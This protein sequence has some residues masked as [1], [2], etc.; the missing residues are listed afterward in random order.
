MTVYL[1]ELLP[2]PV[3]GF[4]SGGG[5]LRITQG[6]GVLDLSGMDWTPRASWFQDEIEWQLDP[7]TVHWTKKLT[8]AI[9]IFPLT[10]EASADVEVN[11]IGWGID[12]FWIG[13]TDKL[14][15]SN[16]FDIHAQIV[17]KSKPNEILRIGYQLTVA[18]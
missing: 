11:K 17:L 2:Q 15:H 5:G 4:D 7:G 9:L 16:R 18:A 12:S 6:V 14:Q 10:F 1:S 3:V 13:N 8:A